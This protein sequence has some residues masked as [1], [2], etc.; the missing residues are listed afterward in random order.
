MCQDGGGAGRGTGGE[1]AGGDNSAAMLLG[2]TFRVKEKT[3]IC[4]AQ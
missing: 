1:V 3:G 2:C 4:G